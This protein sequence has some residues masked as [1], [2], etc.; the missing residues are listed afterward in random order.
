MRSTYPPCLAM[1]SAWYCI[2]GLRPMSPRTRTCTRG[3]VSSLLLVLASYCDGNNSR[4]A[5]VTVKTITAR[6]S[7]TSRGGMATGTR[8]P[9]L[10]RLHSTTPRELQLHMMAASLADHGEMHGEMLAV[11]GR[12]GEV[13]R[14]M[15]VQPI[16]ERTPHRYGDL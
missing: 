4:T 7:Q 13:V 2:R 15:K 9:P 11:V 12:W 10:H 1:L 6:I 14:K 16:N 3:P 5:D 8:F